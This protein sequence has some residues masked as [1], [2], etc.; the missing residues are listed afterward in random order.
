MFHEVNSHN[1]LSMGYS[2][3]AIFEEDTGNFNKPKIIGLDQSFLKHAV[4]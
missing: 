4:T 1:H 3:A 2:I